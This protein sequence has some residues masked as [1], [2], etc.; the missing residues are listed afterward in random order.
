MTQQDIMG[1][2]R[3]GACRFFL[4]RYAGAGATLA[5]YA[6]I[7]LHQNDFHP[8]RRTPGDALLGAHRGDRSSRN[9]TSS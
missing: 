4:G 2:D 9:T 6:Y 8:A 7:T 3:V 5:E 1:W